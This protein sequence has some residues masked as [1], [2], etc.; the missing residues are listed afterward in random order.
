MNWQKLDFRLYEKGKMHLSKQL[1]RRSKL[2]QSQFQLSAI[3]N[4]TRSLSTRDK[5]L[6]SIGVCFS[7]VYVLSVLVSMQVGAR[8]A[9]ADQEVSTPSMIFSSA[10][11]PTP[12]PRT[13]ILNPPT[14]SREKV[15][16]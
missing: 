12:T 4:P 6:I 1:L 9:I 5:V 2:Q 15:P 7:I 8:Q 10:T 14:I 11:D 16:S 3:V 13:T